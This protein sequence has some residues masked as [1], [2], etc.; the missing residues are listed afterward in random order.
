MLDQC[1][2]GTGSGAPST[3]CSTTF[4]LCY[5]L[6][7]QRK[8]EREDTTCALV[9]VEADFMCVLALRLCALTHEEVWHAFAMRNENICL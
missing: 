3:A 4:M 8:T 5:M 6:C 2:F 7:M 9:R 1:S